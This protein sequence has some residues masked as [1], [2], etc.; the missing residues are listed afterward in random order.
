MLRLLLLLRLALFFP[1]LFFVQPTTLTFRPTS[2]LVASTKSRINQT[3][4]RCLKAKP[5]PIRAS[6]HCLIYNVIISYHINVCMSSHV[7]I[8]LASSRTN[9]LDGTQQN[10]RIDSVRLSPLQ[11]WTFF[12]YGF[13]FLLPWNGVSCHSFPN[14]S[15]VT[16]AIFKPSLLQSRI[17][18]PVY[19]E[20]VWKVH[21][22]PGS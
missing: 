6:G 22:L 7:Q 2:R 1:S 8:P 21:S 4:T 20:Q 10:P 12:A 18:L 11:H 3:L 13:T 14:S 17:L 16:R 15:Y 9:S 19:R 5:V